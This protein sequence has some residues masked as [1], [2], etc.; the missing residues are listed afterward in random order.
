MKLLVLSHNLCGWVYETLYREQ[1]ALRAVVP[2]VVFYGPGFRYNHNHVKD[3]IKEVYGAGRPD[4][5]ICYISERISEPLPPAV[6]ERFKVPER[7]RMFPVGLGSVDVPKILWV[8]DFWH[9]SRPMWEKIILGNRF[10]AVAGT[11]CPPFV[12]R[13]V[14]NDFFGEDLRRTVP[15]YPLPRAMD[16]ALFRDYGLLKEYDVTLLG[17]TSDFY[18]LRRYFHETLK[19]QKGIRYYNNAHPGYHYCPPEGGQGLLVGEN[20]ARA[21]NRSRIF[22]SC[23]GKYRIPFIKLYEVL[24]CNTLLMCDRP[25]GAGE[26]G[27]VDGETY[28]EVDRVNF[29][30]KIH[31]YLKRPDDLRRIAQNGSRLFLERHTVDIRAR[32]LKTLVERVVSEAHHTGAVRV[33]LSAHDRCRKLPARNTLKQVF[34]KVKARLRGPSA[35]ARRTDPWPAPQGVSQMDFR[36]VSQDVHILELG[37]RLE[38]DDHRIFLKFG[39]NADWER[40]PPVLTQHPEL[41][42]YRGIYLRLLAERIKARKFC[43][44]GTA[45]G[46]QSLL[47]AGYLEKSGI[48]DGSV[49]TCDITPHEEPIYRTPLT[50]PALWTREELWRES[51]LASRVRFIEGDSGAMARH[52]EGPVDMAYID[53]LHTY[54]AVIKDF[55]NIEPFLSPGGVV[56]FDD[57]DPRFPGVE[58]A[59][60]EIAAS[61]GVSLQLVSFWPSYYKVAV[62]FPAESSRP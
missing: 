2:D 52:M 57:C 6:T 14:F 10:S 3:I 36:M 58:R 26:L 20:Y 42:V 24:A 1:Q 34:L 8:N 51:P 62:M 19:G 46:L 4:A 43:E 15:F 17:A 56:V 5:I 32:E 45:R 27:L 60:C 37:L 25:S 54:E 9:C 16:P 48:Q 33:G 49:V 35:G 22:L 53:G 11:Y 39:V 55:R 28:V 18:P 30:E 13:E 41:V 29:L 23:T 40:D 7:L 50:G 47:W 59:A 31:Y 61:R 12:S 38:P 44:V 21:I